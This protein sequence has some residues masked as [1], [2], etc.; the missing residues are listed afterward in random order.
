MA[1]TTTL[2][3]SGFPPTP[4]QGREDDQKA[5]QPALWGKTEEVRFFLTV[6]EKDRH[7]SQALQGQ[8]KRE[9]RLSVHKKPHGEDR[10]QWVQIIESSNGL[11]GRNI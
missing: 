4:H 10:E 7:S 8:L 11:V 3:P 6:E 2:P 9:E 1:P 5:R